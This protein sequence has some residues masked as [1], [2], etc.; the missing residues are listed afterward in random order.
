[1][2]SGKAQPGTIKLSISEQSF[3]RLQIFHQQVEESGATLLLGL[4]WLLNKGDRDS[5]ATA[6]K[7]V[8][9][10]TE[11]APLVYEKDFNLKTDSLLFTDTVYHLS[12]KGRQIRSSELT[13]QL[14]SILNLK[15]S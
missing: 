15:P 4:P 2:L 9:Q 5:L 8:N 13:K 11:I 7:F 10:L 12:Y 6:Q 3:K 14:N 1:M